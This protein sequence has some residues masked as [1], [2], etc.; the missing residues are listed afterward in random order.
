MHDESKEETSVLAE[1][2][3]VDKT[4]AL[5]YESKFPVGSKVTD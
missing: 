4:R 1:F 2:V 3:K 5:S